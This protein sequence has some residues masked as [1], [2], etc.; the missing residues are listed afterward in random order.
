MFGG[1]AIGGFWYVTIHLPTVEATLQAERLAAEALWR[2]SGDRIATDDMWL[3]E[4]HR[5][6]KA[7]LPV[8][9]INR[10]GVFGGRWV[11]RQ[12]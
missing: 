3:D 8:V 12:D 7:T 9:M 1:I 6:I 11:I 4:R 5:G 10:E 2:H